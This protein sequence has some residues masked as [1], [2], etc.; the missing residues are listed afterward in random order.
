MPATV[1]LTVSRG[2][3]AGRQFVFGQRVT[4]ILGRS[5][6]CRPAVPDDD[7]HKQISRHHCLLDIN[8][9]DVRVRDFG[10]LNGTFVNG[11]KIGQRA[12]DA[13]PG[14]TD[15]G[16]FPEH[17]LKDGD[18]L[19]L[20]P[21]SFR[22]SIFVPALCA[23]CGAEVAAG[24]SVCDGCR[25]RLRFATSTTVAPPPRT[26]ARCGRDVPLDAGGHRTGELLCVHCKADPAGVVQ[27]ALTLA[28]AGERE[29]LPLQ[30]YDIIRELGRGGMGAVYLARRKS[31]GE[32]VA[33]KVML[34]Q[35]ALNDRA[36]KMFLREV[37]NTR[38][39]RH[40]NLV[41][42]RHAASARGSFFL[43]LEYC[44]G[45]SAA[46][47]VKRGGPQPVAEAVAIIL[48]ALDGLH[49]AHGAAVPNIP[50]AD[51]G[52]GSGK[53]LVH[54]DLKPHNIFLCGSG[55]GRVAKVG[56]YG[57]A[58]AFDLAGLS[59]QT[60]TGAIAGTPGFMPRQQVIDFRC[61]RPEVD[62]WAAAASLYWLLTGTTPRD[63]PRSKDPWQIVL[64]DAPV[65]IRERRTDIPPKLAAVI[66]E[67]LRDRPDIT[68][69]T[70]ADL[71]RALEEA[72]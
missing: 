44:D 46:D 49:Y 32:P 48:Q 17:D 55:P 52:V 11:L 3:T 63:F 69:R 26:C 16:A 10:S 18:E 19:Q 66:D 67:A 70:A 27:Q 45:G 7:D 62:V 40:A 61:A 51:G 58:K 30:D 41:G 71:K 33:L 20:G 56:D 22:V 65:P 29:L 50:L 59:G 2:P 54:R 37:E 34:P 1:T 6:D 25:G 36:R 35:V 24:T 5:K 9:P 60:A 31:G 23:G 43:T 53:G 64:Q 14:D 8:P 15:P 13:R 4:C 42:L 57:L 47:L 68:F 39:L 28:A 72:V 21:T 12:R 38:A